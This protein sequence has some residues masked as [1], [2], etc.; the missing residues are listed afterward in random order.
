MPQEKGNRMR[1]SMAALLTVAVSAGGCASSYVVPGGPAPLARLQ[2]TDSALRD[3]YA[4][5]PAAEFPAVVAVSRLQSSGYTSRTAR[6]YGYGAY[7]VVTTRDV[8]SDTD[9]SRLAAMPGVRS[10]APINRMLLS[11][12]M[13]DETA[14][15]SAAARL[16]ADV[17]LMYT[18][19][20]QFYEKDFAEPLSIVT[21]GLSP[22]KRAY[23]TTTASA[24]LVDAR[25]GYV[26]GGAETTAKT[27]QAANAWTSDDAVDDSRRRTERESFG[28]LVGELE[29]TWA[30]VVKQ[31]AA[32]QTAAVR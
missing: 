1:R 6:S 31:H 14:L 11:P 19:D 28:K 32:P 29:K 9:I 25:T 16:R 2:Q 4:A 21:L 3:E 15:R 26:Y 27:D 10:L 23:V 12:E 20:T 7:S 5:K 17:L 24:L 18:F 8:E 13:K 22:N 30:G